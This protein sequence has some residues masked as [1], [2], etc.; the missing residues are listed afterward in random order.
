M[1]YNLALNYEDYSLKNALV[2]GNC[3][4]H[5]QKAREGHLGDRTIHA[6]IGLVESIPII[7][8][9]SSIFE[10]IVVSLLNYLNAFLKPV[11]STK[12]TVNKEINTEKF[13]TTPNAPVN[14]ESITEAEMLTPHEIKC[15]MTIKEL[16]ENAV[17]DLGP[18]DKLPYD[19]FVIKMKNAAFKAGIQQPLLVIDIKFK[20]GVNSYVDEQPY[21]ISGEEWNQYKADARKMC[22][23]MPRVFVVDGSKFRAG[24]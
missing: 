9:I 20:P 1:L 17:A 19:E 18:M 6:L 12:V 14:K 7:S 2:W 4:M 15:L 10:M 8:Q 16:E 22:Q 13:T 5:F 24:I 3:S 23:Y 21:P 11:G